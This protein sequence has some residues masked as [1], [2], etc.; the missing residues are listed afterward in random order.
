MSRSGLF[1]YH[2]QIFIIM[3]YLVVTSRCPISHENIGGNETVKK[4][5]G[6]VATALRRAMKQEGGTWVCWGDGNL[7]QKYPV[8]DFE[9]YKIVRVFMTARERRGFYDDYANGTLWPLFHYFRG[10][11]KLTPTGF[12][13]YKRIN[14]KFT[15]AI[16]KHVNPGEKIWIHDYQL[17]LIPRMLRDSGVGNFII[18]TW[19]IPWVASEFFSTLP[20][21]AQLVDGMIASDMIT[22]H[23]DL[24]KK[25]FEESC[26]TL[27]GDRNLTSGK[28][29]TFSLGIDT[30]YYGGTSQ[31]KSTIEL[32][33]NRKLIFSIDRLDYT[34]GL[35]NRAQAI[36]TLLKK[37][38]EDARKFNYVMI[39]TPSRTSVSEYVN[40]KKDLEMTV[41]RINGMHSDLSWQPIIYLYRRVTDKQL[42]NYYKSA[43]VGLITPLID[44]LNL[45]SK[46]FVAATTHGVLILSQFAGAS[47]SLPMALRVNPN[48]IEEVAEEIHEAMHMDEEEIMTRLAS[49]KS[50]VTSRDLSWWLREIKN[51]AEKRE[52]ELKESSDELR[53]FDGI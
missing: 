7:D 24:Y 3:S 13:H 27:L 52:L 19:H 15:D 33:N 1:K 31:S 50:S 35:S 38:P 8:E 36:E 51:T 43:D 25:N 18:F 40:M 37:H 34:K 12:D 30:G 23:T 28:L 29:F 17:T 41:G 14:E 11:M 42:I 9:G 48:D 21:A 46:E 2:V 4:N 6:G 32:K 49:M 5:V 39:V 45:V 16:L 53:H 20:K 47:F 44:G 22:F 26:E 10:R